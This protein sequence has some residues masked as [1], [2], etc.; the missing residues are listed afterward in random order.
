MFCINVLNKLTTKKRVTIYLENL[1]KVIEKHFNDDG[2]FSYFIDKSQTHYYGVKI[3]DGLQQ[4]DL[5][6]TLLFV[7]ALSMIFELQET[8]SFSWSIIKP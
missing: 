6:G 7:W 4:S 1:I 3:T 8:S 5:H 2:G